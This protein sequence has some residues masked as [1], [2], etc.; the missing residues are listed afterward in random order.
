MQ[1]GFLSNCNRTHRLFKLSRSKRQRNFHS[2]SLSLARSLALS[3]SL[4]LARSSLALSLSRSLARSSLALSLS[5]SLS[6]SLSRSVALSHSLSLTLSLSLSLS[7]PHSLSSSLTLSITLTR[8]HSLSLVAMVLPTSKQSLPCPL[9]TFKISKCGSASSGMHTRAFWCVRAP[10]AAL[11]SFVSV[12]PAALGPPDNPRTK[13]AHLRIP[14]FRE[15]N[16]AK[17]G[18][19]SVG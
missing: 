19:S 3:R 15:R 8:S 9:P 14:T 2:R 17:L 12:R 5:R 7:L 13:R 10:H 18:R 6:L 1:I 16:T 4:S 11:T